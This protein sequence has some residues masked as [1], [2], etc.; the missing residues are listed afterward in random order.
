MKKHIAGRIKRALALSNSLNAGLAAIASQLVDPASSA[1]VR[2]CAGFG[3]E[4]V[5]GVISVAEPTIGVGSGGR[6]D[7]LGMSSGQGQAFVSGKRRSVFPRTKT[8]RT[9][10]T[11]R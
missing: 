4:C 7:S 10:I 5:T 3:P 6:F 2:S 1:A 9:K 8:V 11:P